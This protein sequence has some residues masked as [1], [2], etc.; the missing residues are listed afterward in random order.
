MVQIWGDLPPCHFFHKSPMWHPVRLASILSIIVIIELNRFLDIDWELYWKRTQTF[1]FKLLMSLTL[2]HVVYIIRACLVFG[3]VALPSLHL[4]A[5]HDMT[6]TLLLSSVSLE[7]S[8]QHS[9]SPRHII[10]LIYHTLWIFH[11]PSST[12]ETKITG[13]LIKALHLSLILMK[14]NAS[15]FKSQQPKPGWSYFKVI[16]KSEHVKRR[17]EEACL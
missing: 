12:F 15:L 4:S 11:L 1:Q 13:V 3:K 2:M 10:F 17:F 5:E 16:P 6:Q 9:P 7:Y 14:G 8:Q